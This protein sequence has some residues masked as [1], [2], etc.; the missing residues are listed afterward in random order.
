[1]LLVRPLPVVVVVVIV[2]VVVVGRNVV[3]TMVTLFFMV[4]VFDVA[5]VTDGVKVVA[6][7]DVGVS[8]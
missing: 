5:V 1:M 3:V 4:A 6:R 7:F 2:V 8:D